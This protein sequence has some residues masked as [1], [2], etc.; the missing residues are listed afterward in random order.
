MKPRFATGLV[1]LFMLISTVAPVGAIPI[2]STAPLGSQ[3]SAATKDAR[4]VINEFVPKGTEWVE[5][6]NAGTT[7]QDLTGWQL[8]NGSGFTDTLTPT[9]T[10]GAFAVIDNSF[11][12]D[13]S[14]D[15]IYLYDDVGTLIDSVAYGNVGGAPLAEVG[16]SAARLAGGAD[17]GDDAADWNLDLTPTQGVANDVPGVSLGSSVI[18]NEFDNYPVASGPDQ[19]ELFNPTGAPVDITNWMLSDG[20]HPAD[21]VRRRGPG[22]RLAGADRRDRFQHRFQQR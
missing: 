11:S 5:L 6:Y 10:A 14:G 20:R 13:N 2:Q 17:T 19:V 18:L 9:L 1:V 12:L 3:L 15:A 7:A 16:H 8:T 22:W 21:A 4:V